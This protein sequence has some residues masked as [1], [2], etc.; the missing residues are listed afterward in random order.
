MII[1][2][3]GL[4]SAQV[5]L[6]GHPKSGNGG[7]IPIIDRSCGPTGLALIWNG[8]P[9]S[10]LRMCS[11]PVNNQ[12][13]ELSEN[14]TPPCDDKM[15][16]LDACEKTRLAYEDALG[17]LRQMLAGTSSKAAYDA[18][19]ERI[20]RLRL[21]ARQAERRLQQHTQKHSC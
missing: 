21:E 9:A 18:H 12:C 2:S 10:Q 4:N 8:T 14:E 19:S 20:E 16:L 5:S 15:L 7:R 1:P 11:K 3:I 13:M 17:Q 6:N